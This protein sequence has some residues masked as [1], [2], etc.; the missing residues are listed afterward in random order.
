[1][2]SCSSN[3]EHWITKV[4]KLE[5]QY[6]QKKI[7]L[8]SFKYSKLK[9]YSLFITLLSCIKHRSGYMHCMHFPRGKSGKL[10]IYFPVLE[11]SWK[12]I[13]QNVTFTW[14]FYL[15]E[16]KHIFVQ[17]YLDDTY[18]Y[19]IFYNITITIN[20]KLLIYFYINKNTY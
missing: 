4:A 15:N 13:K 6:K 9:H 2:I 18:E 19:I 1:M 5:R 3:C 20:N 8:Y 14:L 7:A 11:N 12:L 16:A 17:L 10:M